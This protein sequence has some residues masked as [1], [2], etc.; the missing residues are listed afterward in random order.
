V[1]TTILQIASSTT[2]MTMDKWP[3]IVP[4]HKVSNARTRCHYRHCQPKRWLS[5][6]IDQDPVVCSI[7]NHVVQEWALMK[8][9][10]YLL[11]T[12][13]ASTAMLSSDDDEEG[14]CWG[15]HNSAPD[16]WVL[17]YGCIPVLPTSR[18]KVGTVIDNR[19]QTRWSQRGKDSKKVLLRIDS[20]L[21]NIK[22]YPFLAWTA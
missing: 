18:R 14:Q 3:E 6:R 15:T 13:R 21:N 11:S 12:S 9:E 2:N 8:N 17:A 19:Y 22:F 7:C 20:Q 1:Q 5:S 10:P 4:Q 16:D